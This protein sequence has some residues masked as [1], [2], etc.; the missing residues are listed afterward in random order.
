MAGMVPGDLAAGTR[1]GGLGLACDNRGMSDPFQPAPPGGDWKNNA[2]L[3]WDMGDDAIAMGFAEAG[4]II[5]DRWVAGGRNDQLFLPIVFVYRHA[6][7][8][9]LKE[10]IR[11]AAALLRAQGDADPHLAVNK[12]DDYLTKPGKGHSLARLAQRL[13]HLL[14]R[15]QLG[16]LPVETHNA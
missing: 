10:G 9:V 11:Q 8:L 14:G 2:V 5:V 6:L 16:A 3:T 4:S 13:D 12:L 15:L 1:F 7:E